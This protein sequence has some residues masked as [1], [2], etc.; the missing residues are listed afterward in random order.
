M[1]KNSK[2][3][4]K[5]VKLKSA[6]RDNLKKRKVQARKLKGEGDEPEFS[7]KLRSRTLSKDC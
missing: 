1:V 3:P 6:L 5:A 2:N 4:K 7:V